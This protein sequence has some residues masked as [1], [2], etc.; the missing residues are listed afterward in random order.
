M[1]VQFSTTQFNAH[2]DQRMGHGTGTPNSAAVTAIKACFSSLRLA[3]VAGDGSDQ[4]KEVI[5]SQAADHLYHLGEQ[6]SSNYRA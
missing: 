2:L 1:A 6:Y 4:V 5:L 3:V